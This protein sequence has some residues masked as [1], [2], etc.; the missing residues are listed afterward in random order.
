VTV[1]AAAVSDFMV[2]LD[3]LAYGIALASCS[4]LLAFFLH[5][6][7]FGGKKVWRTL[8]RQS[9]CRPLP[10]STSLPLLLLL[11]LLNHDVHLTNPSPS[12]SSAP[13]LHC[14]HASY[15]SCT[16]IVRFTGVQQQQQQQPQ[17]HSK[18]TQPLLSY[19]ATAAPTRLQA[20]TQSQNKNLVGTATHGRT[21]S[22]TTAAHLS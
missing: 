13:V 11:L 19:V 2:C 21:D 1:A 22:R 18:K 15:P 10:L 9:S 6:G 8:L 7:N 17:H 20:R 14:C 12:P 3:C 5:C 4:H 16:S